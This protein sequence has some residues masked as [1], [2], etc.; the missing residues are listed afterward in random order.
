MEIHLSITRGH[1]VALFKILTLGLLLGFGI[2]MLFAWTA[3]GAAAPGGNVAGP[4]TTGDDQTKSGSLQVT[5]GL[6]APFMVD[7]N[8][9]YTYLDPSG[10]SSLSILQVQSL[11]GIYDC[12]VKANVGGNLYCGVDAVGGGGG[13]GGGA[14]YSAGTGLS[15][16]GSTFS[17]D[18]NY[19]Q[20]RVS[21][22]CAAGSSIRSIAADGTVTCEADDVGA[23]GSIACNWSGWAC[24]VAAHNLPHRNNCQG[25]VSGGHEGN[26]IATDS[27]C[28]PVTQKITQMR[29][30]PSFMD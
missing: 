15:L 13:G 12:D 2:Q 11:A 23:G 5:G 16:S 8:N 1:T 14:A 18:T 21:S 20:R 4:L 30:L 9:V 25:Y 17:A 28:D 19:L 22:N 24:Q 10:V 3:P 6:A 7:T 26:Y 27:Y 29:Y